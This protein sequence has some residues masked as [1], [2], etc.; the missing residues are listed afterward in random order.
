MDIFHKSLKKILLKSQRNFIVTRFMDGP[1]VYCA[2]S[3][4]AQSIFCAELILRVNLLRCF[5]DLRPF[6]LPFNLEQ[7]VRTHDLPDCKL[8]ALPTVLYST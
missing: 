4:T 1:A 2:R 7:R 3:L 8:G 5:I 6:Y